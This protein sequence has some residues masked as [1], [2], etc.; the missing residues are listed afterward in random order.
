MLS[1]SQGLVIRLQFN[2]FCIGIQT[3]SECLEN[4]IQNLTASCYKNISIF[5][6]QTNRI[7]Q[8]FPFHDSLR[9]RNYAVDSKY[10][11]E[12]AKCPRTEGSIQSYIRRGIL[13]L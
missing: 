3:T 2:F 10:S 13:A 9:F 7:V 11:Q 12:H 1:A 4:L 8:S 5:Q 6:Y